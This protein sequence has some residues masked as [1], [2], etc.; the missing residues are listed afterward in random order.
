MAVCVR[1]GKGAMGH[2]G[3]GGVES[4]LYPSL[5]IY[6]RFFLGFFLGIFFYR[7][8]LVVVFMISVDNVSDD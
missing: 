8:F 6:H 1:K 5:I 4:G 2:F 3:D 7:E